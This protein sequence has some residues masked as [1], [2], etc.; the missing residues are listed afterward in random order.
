MYL[1]LLASALLVFT[2]F[3][4]AEPPYTNIDNTQLKELIAQG[5]PVFDVR[6]QDEW[7]Q[8]GVI[9]GSQLLTF[10]D[11]GGRVKA[12]FM[13]RFTQAINKDEPVILICRTGNRS[14]TL[15][16]HL[17]EQMGFT[18]VYNVKNGITQWIRDGNNITRK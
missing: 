16:R 1:R 5:I 11:K 3:G 10:V 12:D 13:P 7:K 4:C 8:T 9:Q 14:G 18:H 2:L 17:M 15:A 6:R